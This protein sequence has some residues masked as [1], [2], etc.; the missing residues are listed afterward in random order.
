MSFVDGLCKCFPQCDL[1]SGEYVL[2]SAGEILILI[3][4]SLEGCGLI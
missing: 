1:S 3:K 4:P 2:I